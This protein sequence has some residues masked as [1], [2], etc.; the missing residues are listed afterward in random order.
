MKGHSPLSRVSLGARL[1]VDSMGSSV[2]GKAAVR[3]LWSIL[4]PTSPDTHGKGYVNPG[5]LGSVP[6]GQQ[7]PSPRQSHC[8]GGQGLLLHPGGTAKDKRQ[9][10]L[11]IHMNLG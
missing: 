10:G 6:G 9:H 7:N 2:R 8:E 3:Q 5:G 11:G 4:N 1:A